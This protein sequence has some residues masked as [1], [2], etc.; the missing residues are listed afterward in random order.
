MH[1]LGHFFAWK[2]GRGTRTKLGEDLWVG[3]CDNYRIS[4]DLRRVLYNIGFS[5]LANVGIQRAQDRWTQQWMS[6]EDL[7]L[8][9]ELAEE[10]TTFTILL[11]QNVNWLCDEDNELVWT[12]NKAMGVLSTKLPLI[13]TQW[14]ISG[15]GP[16]FGGGNVP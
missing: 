1:V 11:S 5:I 2:I 10:W 9:G 6:M 7:G 4:Q 8:N 14:T 12:W 3:A 13:Q 15:G 16:Y